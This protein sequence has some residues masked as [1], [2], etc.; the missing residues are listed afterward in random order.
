[1]TRHFK[2][3]ARKEC[4]WKMF[5][6]SCKLSVK[7]CKTWFESQKDTLLQTHTVQVWSG[8]KRNDSTQDISRASTD[9]DSMEINMQSDT[10]IQQSVTSLSAG[11]KSS[12]VNQQV[13][14]Q[15]A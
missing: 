11:F 8:S 7:V 13:M 12:T 15:S 10:K 4:L 6:N 1:M 2:D 9:T 14:D 5:T 3:Q